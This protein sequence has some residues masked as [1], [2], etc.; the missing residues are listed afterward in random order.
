MEVLL[1]KNFSRQDCLIT[2]GGGITGDIGVRSSGRQEKL[3]VGLI[4]IMIFSEAIAL[5]GLIIA[6]VMST[7]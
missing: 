5:Y 7:A 3:Y 6:L 4:L 1:N 2:L